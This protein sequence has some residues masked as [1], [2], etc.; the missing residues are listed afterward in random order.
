VTLLDDI[1]N[2]GLDQTDVTTLPDSLVASLK[3]ENY[4]TLLLPSSL[5]GKQMAYPEYI[6]LV[7]EVAKAD[8][9]TAWCVGQGSV[10]STLA[11]LLPPEIAQEIWQSPSTALANGPP[12][13]C[14]SQPTKSGY[15]LTGSW[16]F[17]SGINHADWLFGM[18]PV[19]KNQDTKNKTGNILWHLFPK[20]SAA[21]QNDWP[22]N[23]LRATGSFDFSVDNLDIPPEYAVKVEVHEDDDDLYQI[24]MNLLFAGGFAAVA[25]G[26]SRSALDFSIDKLQQKIKRFD[27]KTMNESQLTQD[28]IGRAEATWQAAEAYLL[29]T[30]DTVWESI[31]ELHH[32]TFEHKVQLR[33]AATHAIRQSKVVTDIAYDLCSSTSIFT[34]QQI[35][36][37]FQDMHII[38]QHL[39]GR[40]EIYSLVGK[41]YL[42]LP[43]DSYLIN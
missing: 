1:S 3:S 19:V 14:K 20:T 29:R 17:S 42:G 11:R 12:G 28:A 16:T 5:G 8:G 25:L 23:G 10:L 21:I 43:A 24:P 27:Q 38:T 4:F 9:S 41:H 31:R 18:A 15:S 40:P 32:C 7:E 34:H 37:R 2:F 39:Q 13:K 33:L 36:K 6:R 30:I 35:Q 26:V 22:V